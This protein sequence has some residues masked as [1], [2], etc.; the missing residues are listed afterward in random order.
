MKSTSLNLALLQFPLA[1]ESP[2]DNICFFERKD[3]R[4]A[5]SKS[6]S[7]FMGAPGNVVYWF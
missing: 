2:E 4:G 7:R 1:W 3:Y 6:S 5:L